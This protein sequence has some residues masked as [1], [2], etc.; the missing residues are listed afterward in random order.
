MQDMAVNKV[1]TQ[2]EDKHLDYALCA[3]IMETIDLGIVILGTKSNEL[4]FKNRVATEIFQNNQALLEYHNIL[5]LLLADYGNRPEDEIF[6]KNY[7]LRF[8]N[9]LLGYTPYRISDGYI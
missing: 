1:L 6:E 4:I 7:T 5:S 3:S 2:P 9:R 8:K